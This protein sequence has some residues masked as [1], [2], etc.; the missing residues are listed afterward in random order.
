MNKVF[1]SVLIFFASLAVSA[2]ER[3]ESIPLDDL[4]TPDEIAEESGFP[5]TDYSQVE[6]GSI[7]E[8]RNIQGI[9]VTREYPL[10]LFINKD[11]SGAHSQKIKIIENGVH[12]DTWKVSTGRERREVAKSGKRYFS[13]TPVGWFTPYSLRRNHYSRTWKAPMPFSVFFNGGIALHATTRGH[14]RELG[15]RASGG[16]VRLTRDNAEILF[17]KVSKAGQGLVPVVRRNGSVARDAS[18]NVIREV[19]WRTLIVVQQTR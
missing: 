14:Y 17:E 12:V 19:K 9:D 13:A 4:M 2:Q 10:V 6:V 5:R 8:L 7:Q 1:A 11:S 16:C 3:S 18:G 15:R